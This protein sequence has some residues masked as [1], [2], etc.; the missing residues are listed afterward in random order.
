M[1]SADTSKSTHE[2]NIRW[3]NLVFS[4]NYKEIK[5]YIVSNYYSQFL[6]QFQLRKET[7]RHSFECLFQYFCRI[8]CF[9]YFKSKEDNINYIVQNF[10]QVTVKVQVGLKAPGGKSWTPTG[11]YSIFKLNFE[12]L[13]LI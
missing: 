4:K 13:M 6:L 9:T 1:I 10:A 11:Y 2:N 12:Y 8:T 7:N 5:L 3:N